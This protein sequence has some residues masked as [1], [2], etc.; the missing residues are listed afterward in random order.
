MNI[1]VKV[2]SIFKQYLNQTPIPDGAGVLGIPEGSTVSQV[3]AVLNIPGD[4]EK[5]CLVNG[6]TADQDA[7]LKRGDVSTLD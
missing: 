3:L 6:R 7:V 4:L 5:V 2:F 1:E